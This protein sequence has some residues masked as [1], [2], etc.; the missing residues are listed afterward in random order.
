MGKVEKI[1]V[2]SVLFLIVLILTISL[3]Q[4][5]YDPALAKDQLQAGAEPQQEANAGAE[6]TSQIQAPPLT[7][8]PGDG[9][10]AHEAGDSSW[11]RVGE[12]PTATSPAGSLRGTEGLLDSSVKPREDIEDLVLNRPASG[13]GGQAELDARGYR[14]LPIAL[15]DGWDLISTQGLER[16]PNKTL[17]TYD[18]RA[19][20]TFSSLATFFYGDSAMAELLRRNNETIEELRPGLQILVP[21][22]DDMK[23]H[24]VAEGESLWKIAEQHYRKGTS[25]KLIFDAN[26]DL[27][28]TPDNVK[29][30]MKLLIPRQ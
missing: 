18:C 24:V 8:A 3:T 16:T 4:N 19:R 11:E 20:D 10:L 22:R 29:A 26:R 12:R 2:L 17:L 21:V 30:G 1:V 25:W 27:L 28:R 6:P 13:D 15:E 9:F 14:P 7:G 23:Y 5:P